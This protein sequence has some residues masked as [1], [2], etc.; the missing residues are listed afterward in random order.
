MSFSKAFTFNTYA[1]FK[2]HDSLLCAAPVR[3]SKQREKRA[4]VGVYKFSFNASDWFL[5]VSCYNHDA[6]HGLLG[7]YWRGL[8]LL[9]HVVSNGGGLIL[10]IDVS[11]RCISEEHLMSDQNISIANLKRAGLLLNRHLT[12]SSEHLL[13][14]VTVVLCLMQKFS[15]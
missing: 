10:R 3:E 5:D 14:P 1:A 12:R 7:T 4:F 8:N 9:P 11:I 6:L 15:A 2:A 13:I